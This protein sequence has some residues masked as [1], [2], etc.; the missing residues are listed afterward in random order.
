MI[1]PFY[2][3]YDKLSKLVALITTLLFSEKLLAIEWASGNLTINTHQDQT[4]ITGGIVGTSL[5]TLT[6]NAPII[7]LAPDTANNPGDG[8]LNDRTHRIDSIINNSTITGKDLDF[9]GRFGIGIWNR[10]GSIDLIENNG[11]ISSDPDSLFTSAAIYNDNG[12]LSNWGLIS[13]IINQGTISGALGIDTTAVVSQHSATVVNTGSITNFYNFGSIENTENGIAIANYNHYSPDYEY[14]K[15]TISN[16]YN[17]GNISGGAVGLHNAGVIDSLVNVGTI[18]GAG[19]VGIDNARYGSINTLSNAQSSLTYRGT[20][21]TNYNA[22]INSPTNYGSLAVSSGTGITHFGIESGSTV[23]IGTTTY[24]AVLSGL[25]LSNLAGTTGTFG[26]GGLTQSNWTL[27]NVGGGSVWDLATEDTVKTNATVLN[28]NA[29][30]KLAKA[31]SNSYAKLGPQTT[32]EVPITTVTTTPTIDPPTVPTTTSVFTSTTVTKPPHPNVPT[33]T[34]TTTYTVTKTP[35]ETI[36]SVPIVTTTTTTTTVPAPLLTSVT[37]NTVATTV[38]PVNPAQPT[39]TTVV[40]TKE[41]KETPVVVAL[42]NGKDLKT[43]VQ[44]LTT[45]QVQQL[46]SVHAEGYGSNMTIGLQQMAHINNSVMDRIHSPMSNEKGGAS[47]AYQTDEGR[48]IWIDGA[49]STGKVDSYG[50]LSGFDFN[51]YNLLVGADIFRNSS[52]AL[53]VF[54]GGGATSMTES[55]QVSQSF[56]TTNG[57]AGLYG[58]KYLPWNLKL[59]GSLGYVYGANKAIRD[60]INV[61]DFTGGGGE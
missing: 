54:A 37:T 38:K 34:T 53:G 31:I 25:T 20:L 57:F 15:G 32:S 59:S 39:V 58:G 50:G 35:V 45:D 24:A 30:T 21:P 6:V 23:A 61:G 46:S 26:G 12:G 2:R 40:T 60:N 55:A 1:P 9:T 14:A 17:A 13:S 48:Y 19:D 27:K 41:T 4:I 16:F 29:G 18:I 11:T 43:A 8:V 22:I 28:S 56:N 51:V 49:G 10:V 36:T 47:T 3:D 42:A 5:G 44:V 52:G 7:P 33:S